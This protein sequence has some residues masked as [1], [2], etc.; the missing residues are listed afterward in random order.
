VALGDLTGWLIE[1][2]DLSEL[3]V[4]RIAVGDPASVTI[5]ALPGLT[6][7]GRVDRI[8]VRGTNANGGVLFAVA[9]RPDVHHPEL[10]WNTSA[11]VRIVPSG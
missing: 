6:L 10:R 11:E 5:P 8:Q 4:I 7:N 9:I 2:T 1:T 3:E